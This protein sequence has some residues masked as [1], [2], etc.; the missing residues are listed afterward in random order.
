MNNGRQLALATVA[1]TVCFYGWSLLG[2]LGPDLQD[3]LGL[4]DFQTSAMVAVPVLLGSV[5]PAALGARLSI[6]LNAGP[7][8]RNT[9]IYADIAQNSGIAWGGGASFRVSD[10]L[11]AT[12][13]DK[14]AYDR[15]SVEG[16]VASLP[17]ID[18]A[19]LRADMDGGCK[20]W[21]ESERAALLALGVYATPQVWVNG[22]FQSQST[23]TQ[24]GPAGTITLD[25]PPGP[26]GTARVCYW[27][28]S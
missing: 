20:P 4:S 2:P 26:S 24:D 19:R 21:I 7:M 14:R 11:W 12:A 13:F 22:L 25:N 3:S 27:S 1:F 8:V 23:Y 15:A 10:A 6:S 18:R 9:A 28:V 16:A 17:G 5:T